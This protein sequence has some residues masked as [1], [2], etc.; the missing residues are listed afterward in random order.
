MKNT[1]LNNT[2]VCHW[3]LLLETVFTPSERRRI[4]RTG[5]PI[6]YVIMDDVHDLDNSRNVVFPTEYFANRFLE[7]MLDRPVP[8]STEPQVLTDLIA[9]GY[10]PKYP[11]N[12]FTSDPVLI[13]IETGL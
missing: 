4:F 11:A 6:T 5:I 9:N 7:R 3:Y 1:V 12:A 8:F 10:Q 2:V 13:P